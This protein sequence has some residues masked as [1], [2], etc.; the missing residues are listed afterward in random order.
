MAYPS[1]GGEFLRLMSSVYPGADTTATMGRV[2]LGGLYGLA[3]GAV[4]GWL[5]ALLY[6]TVARA[7]AVMPK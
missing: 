7:A 5:F 2:L 1:Y 4:T 3:G 6:R